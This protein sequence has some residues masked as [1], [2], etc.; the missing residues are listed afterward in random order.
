[1]TPAD[2]RRDEVNRWLAI[3]SRDLRAALLLSVEEPSA[4]VFHSQQAAEKTA[5]AFLTFYNV[6]FRKTHDLTE[7]G[8]QCAALAPSLT[9]LL[10]EAASLTDYAVIFRYLDAPGDPD[11]VEAQAALRTAQRLYEEVRALLVRET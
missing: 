10:T 9:P 8:E 1:M 4:S 2:L 7:L 3:A 11:A 6:V 5:K